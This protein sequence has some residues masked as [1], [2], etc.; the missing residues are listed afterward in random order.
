[1]YVDIRKKKIVICNLQKKNY[2]DEFCKEQFFIIFAYFG[3][4]Q[5]SSFNLYI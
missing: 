5:T 3:N 4:Y 2:R 1:M